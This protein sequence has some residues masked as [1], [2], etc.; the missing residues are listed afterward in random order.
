MSFIRK[1]ATPVFIVRTHLG[2]QSWYEQFK[3]CCLVT[4]GNGSSVKPLV[5]LEMGSSVTIS[6][7]L[8]AVY[9]HVCRND[10]NVR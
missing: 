4:G 6:R 8:M 9:V 5:D 10:G 2:C 1:L 3:M 7:V